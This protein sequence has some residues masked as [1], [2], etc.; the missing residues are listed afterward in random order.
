MLHCGETENTVR[1]TPIVLD[2]HSQG[3][4]SR[5]TGLAGLV[6]GRRVGAT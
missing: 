1:P 5:A 6:A 2:T 4:I 3:R